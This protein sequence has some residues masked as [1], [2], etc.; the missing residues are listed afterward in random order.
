MIGSIEMQKQLETRLHCPL[1]KT[2]EVRKATYLGD[3]A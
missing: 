1:G 2:I 3:Y